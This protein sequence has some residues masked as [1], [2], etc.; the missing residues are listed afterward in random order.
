MNILVTLN[1]N[2]L[3]Y[4]ISLIRSINDNNKNTLFDFYIFSNDITLKDIKKYD[5]YLDKTNKYFIIN[6]PKEDFKNAPITKRY[7]YEMYYRI[8]ASKYLPSSLDRILYLDPDIIV[9]GNLSNLYN[10]NFE[11]NYYAGCTNIRKVLKRI[12]QIK[13]GAEKDNEYINTGVLMINLSTLREHLNEEAVYN[14]I[15]D[16]KY[17]LT[18]PDQD[19]ISTLYG[20]KILLLNTFIYNLSEKMIKI[21][22]LSQKEDKID[23]DWVEKNTIIIHYLGKNKPW[24]ENYKGILLPYYKKYEVK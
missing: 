13:N 21:H 7:P 23:L 6:I 3:P 24:K 20:K 12:N 5:N 16:K 4:L 11:G 8:F 2:Y 14:F 22:N 19:V 15:E 18:L 9:K 17:L 1:K 10:I